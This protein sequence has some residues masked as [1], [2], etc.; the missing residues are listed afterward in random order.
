MLGIV[1]ISLAHSL[2]ATPGADAFTD[3][4]TGCTVR[5]IRRTSKST[6]C[7]PSGTQRPGGYFRC[8]SM[9]AVSVQG[10]CAG[11]F[12]CANGATTVCGG[13]GPGAATCNCTDRQSPCH[14][15]IY[16]INALR[17]ANHSC[18]PAMPFPP[19]P[20]PLPP[21]PPMQPPRPAPAPPHAH[22][23]LQATTARCAN[24]C[25]Y[26]GMRPEHA[27]WC[28]CASC[29]FNKAHRQAEGSPCLNGRI[30]AHAGKVCAA[31]CIAE[32]EK[33]SSVGSGLNA[34][35]SQLKEGKGPLM[36]AGCEPGCAMPAAAREKAATSS[37]AFL[38]LVAGI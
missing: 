36:E 25:S 16:T 29:S 7:W 31:R 4:I 22:P 26:V 18:P 14:L 38:D 21:V 1:H 5:L 6:P 35:S 23:R 37:T 27:H 33:C 15:N 24:F 20:P 30:V 11:L 19:M 2:P 8:E 34:C 17:A 28:K 13:K 12:Q 9:Q 32:F 3:P 10:K